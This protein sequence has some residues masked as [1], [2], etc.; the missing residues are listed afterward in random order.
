MRLQELSDSQA[1]T[2]AASVFTPGGVVTSQPGYFGRNCLSHIW[3]GAGPSCCAFSAFTLSSHVTEALPSA[4][5]LAP[6]DSFPS[7]V[8]VCPGPGSR[9]T[10]LKSEGL[11]PCCEL[12]PSSAGFLSVCASGAFQEERVHSGPTLRL[13]TLSRVTSSFSTPQSLQ[14]GKLEPSRAHPGLYPMF[15]SGVLLQSTCLWLRHIPMARWAQTYLSHRPAEARVPQAVWSVMDSPK[16]WAL[17]LGLFAYCC[18]WGEHVK[19]CPHVSCSH[20]VRGFIMSSSSEVGRLRH[21]AS[22]ASS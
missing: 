22:L 10:G 12:H 9:A 13:Q 16:Y 1:E 2:G 15:T 5:G 11:G 6:S 8:P 14:T 18:L 4:M 17:T 20:Q 19:P 3:M 7:A 21:R